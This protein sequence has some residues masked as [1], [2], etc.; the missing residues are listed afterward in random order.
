MI[1]LMVS[2]YFQHFLTWWAFNVS[3]FD[4]MISSSDLN[5]MLSALQSSSRAEY[6]IKRSIMPISRFRQAST[7]H[8][9]PWIMKLRLKK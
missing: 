5:A 8:V 1:Y 7:R 6:L 9:E 3:N 2:E 4:A